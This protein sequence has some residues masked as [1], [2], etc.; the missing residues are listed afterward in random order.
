MGTVGALVIGNPW[1]VLIAIFVVMMGFQELRALEYEHQLKEEDDAMP[2]SIAPKPSMMHITIC[3]W[4][5]QR[6][7][8]VRRTYDEPVSGMR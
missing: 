1:L 7:Q 6:G 4:D 3:Q 2:I 8:W 5:P